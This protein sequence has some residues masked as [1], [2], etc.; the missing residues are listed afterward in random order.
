MKSKKLKKCTVC[1][2]DY[3]PYNE[4]KQLF[5]SYSC[6]GL[7]TRLNLIIEWYEGREPGVSTNKT[8]KRWLREHLL[9]LN[10]FQCSICNFSGFNPRT[11]KSILEIDHIDGNADNNRPE[12]LRVICPN[13]HAMTPTF[14]ALNVSTRN[15]KK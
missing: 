6:Q 11:Q 14:R 8:A 5:C 4:S 15:R 1:L 9:E 10:N 13:C 12:N 2:K 7:R 3:Y